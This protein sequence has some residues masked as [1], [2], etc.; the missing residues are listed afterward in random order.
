MFV[1]AYNEELA[2]QKTKS[3]GAHGHSSRAAEA[4]RG[5]ALI[6][7][8]LL[9]VAGRGPRT[10]T[11]TPTHTTAA[12]G[13]GGTE[14]ADKRGEKWRGSKGIDQRR[15][16]ERVREREREN[17]AASECQLEGWGSD[18][19]AE[20][21]KS[22]GRQRGTRRNPPMPSLMVWPSGRGHWREV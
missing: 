19:E 18:G 22:R 1:A 7:I 10:N 11:P 4:S 8:F 17:R 3:Y 16:K 15:E 21:D 13:R 9:R 20:E 14:R 6:G 12:E 5:G 2:K